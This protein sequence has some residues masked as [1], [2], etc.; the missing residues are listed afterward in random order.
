MKTTIEISDHLF[1]AAK[2]VAVQRRTT[3]KAM[4]EHALK[5]EIAF[6]EKPSRQ[7]VFEKNAYGFP[8]LRGHAIA[9]VTSEMVYQMIEE[10][11]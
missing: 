3:L 6:E 9:P 4:I 2:A 5:R 10:E 1:T 11:G 8:V 7:A